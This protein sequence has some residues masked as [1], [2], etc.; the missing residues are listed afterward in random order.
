MKDF[1]SRVK[2][3]KIHLKS[4]LGAKASQLNHYIIPT[5]EEYKYDCVIIQIRINDILRNKNDTHMNN[6]PGSIL[7]TANNCQNYNIGK[8]FISAILPS[9]R[10]KVNISQI[11]ET[12]KYL[13]FRNNFIFVEHKKLSF[14]DLWVD[15]IHLLH[16][17]KAV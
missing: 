2:G 4:F 5:L 16:S 7:E 11:N 12:L 6:P 14:D 15:G 13:C 8:I 9:R 1:N 17:G 3:E 10:T